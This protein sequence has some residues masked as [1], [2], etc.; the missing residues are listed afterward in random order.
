M[1]IS[2]DSYPVNTTK[3]ELYT[4]LSEVTNFKQIMP[5]NIS[6]FEVIHQD[7]FKFALKGMPEIMLRF[8]ERTASERVVLG[9]TNEQFPFQL[10]I[11]IGGQEEQPTLGLHFSGS[12]NAMISMMIKSPLTNFIETLA[13][14]TVNHFSA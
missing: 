12:F 9:S 6:V 11:E 7:A 10:K 5:E 2:T 13:S 1:E 4:F 3:N 14:K 8:E